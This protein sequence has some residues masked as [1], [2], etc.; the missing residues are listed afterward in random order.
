MEEYKRSNKTLYH[1]QNMNILSDGEPYDMFL[2]S[3]HEPTSD[4]LREA[5]VEEMYDATENE[6]DEFLTSSRVYKVYMEEI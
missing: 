4:D 3:D 2:L 1:I 5:F 6:I